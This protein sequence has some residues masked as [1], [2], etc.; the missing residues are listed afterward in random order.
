MPRFKILRDYIEFIPNENRYIPLNYSNSRMDGKLP[1]VFLAD[2]V[3]ALPN[4]YAIEAMRSGQLNILN[5]LGCII[6]TKY[7]T[8]NNP[9]EDEV[10]YAK[11]I[12]DGTQ[13]DETV[14]SL[15]YEPENTDNWSFD[16]TILK[17]ANPVALEIPEIW[18][19]LLK[20][21]LEPFLLNP[22][23]KIF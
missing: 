19:D 8:A 21:G 15:L 14:F 16:D 7:P 23:E 1:N 3:G 5:K 20:S 13:N 10:N 2:E 11:R 17:H 4:S 9:F 6:S 18:D 12:L 22:H